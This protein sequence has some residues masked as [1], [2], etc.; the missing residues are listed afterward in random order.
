MKNKYFYLITSI[1]IVGYFYISNSLITIQRANIHNYEISCD[2]VKNSGTY[3]KLKNNDIIISDENKISYDN[4]KVLIKSGHVIQNKVVEHLTIFLGF[5]LM[6]LL[7]M[8]L[9][10]YLID[11]RKEK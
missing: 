8:T 6:Q 11:S 5:I 4:N 2:D 3:F 7:L 10:L 9:N 1:I